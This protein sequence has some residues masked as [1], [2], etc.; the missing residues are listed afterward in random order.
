MKGATGPEKHMVKGPWEEGMM[1]PAGQAGGDIASRASK[2][3]VLAPSPLKYSCG[4]NCGC[5]AK[6]PNFDEMTIMTLETGSKYHLF[7][8]PVTLN[9]S[10]TDGCT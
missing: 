7:S 2:S 4:C 9:N 5:F 6:C 1:W 3:S 8:S 10:R